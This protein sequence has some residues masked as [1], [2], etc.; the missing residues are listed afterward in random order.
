V[1]A[2]IGPSR[3][4]LGPHEKN[5]AVAEMLSLPSDGR[6]PALDLAPQPLEAHRT[7]RSFRQTGFMEA[8]E[9]HFQ[10]A[11]IPDRQTLSEA[12]NRDSGR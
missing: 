6:Y 1:P 9:N 3:T 4:S 5:R 8:V 10:G 11:G 7:P 12:G 2:T